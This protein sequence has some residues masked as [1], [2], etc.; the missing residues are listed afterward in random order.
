MFINNYYFNQKLLIIKKKN[1]QLDK[2]GYQ[3]GIF[4][5]KKMKRHK[6]NINLI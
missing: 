3:I 5:A 6:D 1:K 4:T 2:D